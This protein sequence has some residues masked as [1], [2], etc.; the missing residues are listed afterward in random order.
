MLSSIARQLFEAIGFLSECGYV[1]A[2]IK[3]Q[4]VVY[5]EVRPPVRPAPAPPGCMPCALRAL[6]ALCVL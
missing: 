5:K 2:D 3:P 4:N 6:S 1:H